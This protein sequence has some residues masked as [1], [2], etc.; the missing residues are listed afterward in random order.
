M[1]KAVFEGLVFD[2]HD[3]TLAVAYVGDEP[4]YVVLEDGFKYHV[5]ARKVDEQIIASFRG[6]IEGNQDLVSEGMMKMMGKD[7]L[8]TKAAVTSALKNMEKNLAQLFQTGIPEQARQYLG[9][10]G[11]RVTINRHG[12]VVDINLPA[13]TTDEE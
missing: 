12:D 2:D 10:M 8:F 1:T 7:D 4:T 5:D 11:F 13:T 9:M 3:H 6:Q